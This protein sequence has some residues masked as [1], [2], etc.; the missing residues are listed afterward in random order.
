MCACIETV[1]T[2]V[3]TF[4]MCACIE[5]V[6]TYIHSLST[7]YLVTQEGPHSVLNEDEFFDALEYAYQN[8]EVCSCVS[9]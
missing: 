6:C 3:R 9:I 1:Y 2:Y 7:L 8:E 4:T 5:T